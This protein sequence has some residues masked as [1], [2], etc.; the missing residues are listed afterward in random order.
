MALGKDQILGAPKLAV[1]ETDVP[2]FDAPARFREL[3]TAARLEFADAF[4]DGT[5]KTTAQQ[6]RLSLAFVVASLVDDHDQPLFPK[7]ERGNAVEALMQHPQAT[8]QGLIKACFEVNRMGDAAIKEEVG[9]S[10]SATS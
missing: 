5:E 1:Q 4:A 8:V 3:S 6:M 7:D 2:G 10:E 9:N